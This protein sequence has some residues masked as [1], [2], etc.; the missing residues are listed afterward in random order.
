M[1]QVLTPV[2]RTENLG[3][4]GSRFDVVVFSE[5]N[6]CADNPC[7]N[8]RCTDGDGSYTCECDAWYQ[9]TNCDGECSMNSCAHFFNKNNQGLCQGK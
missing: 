1:P 6:E 2:N 9:G 5:T 3:A 8:G 7:I 4:S